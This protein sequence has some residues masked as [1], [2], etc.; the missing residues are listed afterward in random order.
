M[1]PDYRA[2]NPYQE[3]L[4]RALAPLGVEVVFPSGYKR[5]LPLFRGMRAAGGSFH[6]LHL[7]WLSPFLK[8]G[9][10]FLYPLYALRLLLDLLLCRLLLGS[11]IV[12]TVHNLVSHEDQS[13]AESLV[14][15]VLARHAHRVLVHS[16]AAL[17]R[18]RDAFGAPAHHMSVVPHGEYRL[19]YGDPPSPAAARLA[20]GLP[21]GVRIFLF[22]GL[23]RPYKGIEPLIE[24]WRSLA[25]A[26]AVL[27]IAG[28]PLDDA[29]LDRLRLAA[30]PTTAVLFRPGRVADADLPTLLAAADFFV[31]P[32][33]HILTSGSLLL[34][35]S[36]SLPVIAPAYPFVQEALG[37][38]ARFLYPPSAPSGLPEA[39]ARA[40]AAEPFRPS[41]PAPPW[42]TVA[43]LTAA[44]YAN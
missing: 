15:R 11:R 10:A 2:G 36:Y 5:G 43:A 1:A 23:L 28:Q 19:W 35:Q 6:V 30:G 12:W 33:Q 3:M 16:H 17:A 22:F 8:R 37:P 13:A 39:L 20:L 44:V 27:L 38:D 29:Y 18:V 26:N 32:L 42:S 4:C 41:H 14:R 34:A 24:A 25:P 31:L 40:L 9:P 21:A 7:H